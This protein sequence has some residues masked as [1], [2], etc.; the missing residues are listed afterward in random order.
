VIE[1]SYDALA[2]LFAGASSIQAAQAIGTD[3]RT[4]LQWIAAWADDGLFAA[5][6]VPDQRD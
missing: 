4:V 6:A 3:H 2:G 1:R 5:I